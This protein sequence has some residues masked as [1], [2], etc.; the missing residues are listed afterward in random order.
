MGFMVGGTWAL[1]N[2]VFMA[3]LPAAEHFSTNFILKFTPLGYLCSALFGLFVMLKF[4]SPAPYKITRLITSN[5]SK[6]LRILWTCS[7]CREE[8]TE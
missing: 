8:N 4:R 5:S 7:K 3:L 6:K 2:I 1:A